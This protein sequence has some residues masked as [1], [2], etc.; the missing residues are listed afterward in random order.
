[1]EKENKSNRTVQI[2]QRTLKSVGTKKDKVNDQRANHKIAVNQTKRESGN[3]INANRTKTAHEIQ[4]IRNHE[5]NFVHPPL[6]VR[7]KEHPELRVNGHQHA[8]CPT[9]SRYIEH[10]PSD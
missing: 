6:R 10:C 9:I 1:M 8:G 5:S 7:H 2:C 4:P 3:R